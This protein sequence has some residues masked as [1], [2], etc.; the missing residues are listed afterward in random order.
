M[1]K[2]IA[3]TFALSGLTE[4]DVATTK[5]L[6]DYASILDSLGDDPIAYIV[7]QRI[8]SHAVHGTWVALLLQYLDENDDGSLVP[9]DVDRETHVNQYLAVALSVLAAVDGVAAFLAAKPFTLKV[10]REPVETARNGLLRLCSEAFGSDYEM[11][12]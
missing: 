4:A 11:A 9:R 1:L 6:P 8:G 12:D 3:H 10:L 7:H 5:P 2:S